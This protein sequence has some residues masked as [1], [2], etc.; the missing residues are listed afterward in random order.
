MKKGII[1]TFS[2]IPVLLFGTVSESVLS[3]GEWFKIGITQPG[4]YKI[5]Y[6]FLKN[7][8]LDVNN[9]DPKKIQLYGNGGGMLPQKISSFRVDDLA[10][11]AIE[12][13]G[14]A[15]GKFN[16]GDYIL[17]YSQGHDTWKPDLNQGIFVHSKNIYCDTAYY[18]IT[19]NQTE[20]KRLESQLSPAAS[21]DFQTSFDEHLFHEDDKTNI[22]KSGREWFGD[23]FSITNTYSYNFNFT[24]YV[25]GTPI[26]LKTNAGILFGLGARQSGSVFF[27]YKLNNINFGT[28]SIPSGEGCGE[29]LTKG[30]SL[31]ALFIA[32]PDIAIPNTASITATANTSQD[33]NGK[34]YLN[35]IALN[36]KKVLE[37]RN[38]QTAFRTLD[39]QS[40]INYQ[41]SSVASTS[42]VWDVTTP[43][44]AFLVSNSN[45]NTIE[46]SANQ[47]SLPH[48][49]VAF[50]PEAVNLSPAFIGKVANQNLH[51]MEVPNLLIV[52]HFSLLDQ[53]NQL[54]TL[55]RSQ[56]ISVEIATT[57]QVY[58]EFSSG[59]QDVTA[60]RDLCR[61]LFKKGGLKNL[62]L[63]GSCSYDYKYRTPANTNL[64]PCYESYELFGSVTSYSSEDYY[65][66]FGDNEGNWEEGNNAIDYNMQIGVGRIPVKNASEAQNVVDKLKYYAEENAFGKWR[67]KSI[68]IADNGS[69]ANEFNIFLNDTEGMIRTATSYNPNLNVSK[70]YLCLLYTSPSPRD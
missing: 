38:G 62:L 3:K 61:M 8:G 49:F 29:C 57:S 40:N 70:I 43:Y 15:D 53:A 37:L 54:A 58:N 36:F 9:L 59:G 10:E 26:K 44:R 67:N 23:N 18:F 12:V 56:G 5:D 32:T 25:S 6:N 4:I 60:I 30:N 34:S 11:N 51:G 65:A 42:K 24:G 13:V 27:N 41:V 64:V 22:I 55:R 46:F 45:G 47:D 33:P 28:F 63:F 21:S 35:Y 14:E 39:Q 1:I 52:T 31:G 16:P 2:I 19:Y 50:T 66:F 48:E 20:G 68:F 17:F 69:N 7:I